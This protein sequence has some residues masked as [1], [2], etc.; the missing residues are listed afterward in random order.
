MK[1]ALPTI[2]AAIV[3]ASTAFASAS[4]NPKPEHDVSA[5]IYDHR[6]NDRIPLPAIERCDQ[7]SYGTGDE[8]CGTA[9]GGPVGGLANGN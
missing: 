2:V 7:I 9:T 3:L 5:S 8:S 6:G 1:L 4:T